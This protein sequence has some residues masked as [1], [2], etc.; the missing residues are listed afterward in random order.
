MKSIVANASLVFI[1]QCSA[2]ELYY[3]GTLSPICDANCQD[4]QRRCPLTSFR[5]VAGCYC[6]PN[7]ARNLQQRCI[8]RQRCGRV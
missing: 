8:P 7:Y 2:N 1:V 6:R 4:L 3:N 5:P